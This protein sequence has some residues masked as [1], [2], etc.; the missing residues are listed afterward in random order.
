MRAGNSHLTQLVKIM[1]QYPEMEK[2]V[3]VISLNETDF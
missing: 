2:P 3:I 1:K